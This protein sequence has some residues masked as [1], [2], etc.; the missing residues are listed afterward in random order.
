MSAVA[1]AAERANPGALP[2]PL[3]QVC[4]AAV[5]IGIVSF[6]GGVASDPQT[7]WLS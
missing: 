5:V 3:F 2:K 4:L 1:T 7:A 6:I